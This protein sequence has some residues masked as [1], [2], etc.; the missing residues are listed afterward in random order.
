MSQTKNEEA[1]E[2]SRWNRINILRLHSVRVVTKLLALCL[3][4]LATLNPITSTA[5]EV[6]VN[7]K[8]VVTVVDDAFCQCITTVESGDTLYGYYVY[9]SELTDVDPDTT[10]GWYESVEVPHGIV[11][12]HKNHTF[13]SD[14][15]SPHLY[16]FVDLSDG[17]DEFTVES[18]SNLMDPFRSFLNLYSIFF[19]VFDMT[20]QALTSDSLLTGPPDLPAYT[21]R[22]LQ[23]IGGDLEWRI[24]ADVLSVGSGL[25]IGI[26]ET[27][28]SGLRVSSHPNPFNPSTTITI[29]LDVGGPVDLS[30][31]NVRG[32]HIKTL[33]LGGLLAG[34]HTYEWDGRD[35][36]G[37]SAASGVY[38]ALLK[39]GDKQVSRKLVLLR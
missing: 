15:S 34:P 23:I 3:F 10:M 36:S 39:A 13:S 38:F 12:Y 18:R 5:E 33:A 6:V 2:V 8:A 32:G 28:L 37:A 21:Y 20:G 9:D 14:P 31:Y 25:P 16:V 24:W 27:S 19:S 1:G 26:R 17:R 11:V 30:I 22:D 29:N 4:A 7:F 35:T